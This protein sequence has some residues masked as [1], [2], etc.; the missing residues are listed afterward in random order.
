MY[1]LTFFWLSCFLQDIMQVGRGHWD[2]YNTSPQGF[3]LTI[4]FG[5]LCSILIGRFIRFSVQLF[6]SLILIYRRVS[7]V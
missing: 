1:Y 3:I 7:L 4:F 6:Q 2:V 5:D